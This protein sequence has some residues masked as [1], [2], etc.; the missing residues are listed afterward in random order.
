MGLQPWKLN[1]FLK[2]ELAKNGI[3]NPLH[4]QPQQAD[5]FRNY[6]RYPTDRL[7]RSLGLGA[8]D[9]PAPMEEQEYIVRRVE[10]LLRQGVGAPAVPVVEVGQR[11]E[12]GA[13]IAEIPDGKLG[14]CLHASISG[15]VE[16]IT[17]EKII[18][19]AQV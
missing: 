6:K 1:N 11:V 7:I 8:Y 15:I 3:K 17:E 4:D 2:G 14:S 12:R 13:L 5:P 19:A 16:A 9:V 18:L 10:L